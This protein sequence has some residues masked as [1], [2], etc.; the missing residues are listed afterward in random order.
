MLYYILVSGW[1][2]MIVGYGIV[3]IIYSRYSR[4]D[5]AEIEA[6]T[7]SL[8]ASDEE[9]AER[10]RK[11]SEK[12]HLVEM[13]L[14]E[15]KG[16]IKFLTEKLAERDPSAKPDWAKQSPV[17]FWDFLH[18]MTKDHVTP[19]WRSFAY[20]FK[21][22]TDSKGGSQFIDGRLTVEARN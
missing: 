9:F 3:A 16:Q 7:R 12:L 6:L 19:K 18:D 5:R 8:R 21:A 14:K 4:K 10:M 17:T 15:A 2:G 22:R 11:A 20:T 1:V 13:K